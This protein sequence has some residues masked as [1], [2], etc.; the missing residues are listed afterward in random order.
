LDR[1]AKARGPLAFIDESFL[2]PSQ[3]KDSFYIVAAAV[4]E[5]DTVLTIRQEMR[6]RVKR[7]TWHTTESG[8]SEAGQQKIRELASYLATVVK[9]VIVVVDELAK[10]DR[11]AEAGRAQALRGLLTELANNHI[12]MTGTVVYE[13]RIPGYMQA[14]DDVIIEGIRRQGG[15]ASK[16]KVIGIASKREPLLWIPD[17]ICWAFRQAYLDDD[18]GYFTDLA[19]VATIIHLSGPEQKSPQNH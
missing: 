11:S 16:L 7:G 6:R 9:P 15:D 10:S 8:R 17:L 14:H 5:K 1:I 2:A 4:I 13:K 19:K 12:Y 3:W 18:Q